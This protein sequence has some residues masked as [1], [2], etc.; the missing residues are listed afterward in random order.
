VYI[1]AICRNY[2]ALTRKN[3]NIKLSQLT[4]ATEIDSK[5][6]EKIKS[7]IEKELNA[8]V[9]LTANVKPDIIGGLILRMEDKQFDASVATQ[10]K[11]MR[12]QLQETEISQVK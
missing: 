9:E 6:I 12:Q 3:Q 8:K 1:P 2:L 5:T 10:L 4:T 11:K 7:T